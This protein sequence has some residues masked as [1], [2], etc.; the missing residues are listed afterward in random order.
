MIDWPGYRL[1]RP[2]FAAAMDRRLYTP[3]WLD[4]RIAGG[5]AWLW[6]TDTAAIVAE[7]RFYPTGA[8]DLHG[9]IAAGDVTQIR[10]VLIPRAEAWGR[11]AGCLGAIIESRPGW[12]KILKRN[13]YA[14]WQT[15]LRKEFN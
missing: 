6:R 11:E 7:L 12:A 10:D 4:A 8:R 5:E 2:A 15:A 1:W 3:E 9:L 14:P 13:G